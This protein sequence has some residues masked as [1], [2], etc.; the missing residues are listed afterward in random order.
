MKKIILILF[1]FILSACGNDD[2]S[3]PDQE[4]AIYSVSETLVMPGDEII[5]IGEGFIDPQVRF[6]EVEA[7]I[8][9]ST[10]FQIVAKV[11]DDASSGSITVFSGEKST[12]SIE[13]RVMYP[14]I[15]SLVDEG[16]SIAGGPTFDDLGYEFSS[17]VSGKITHLGVITSRLGNYEITL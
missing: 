11:P 10:E 3:K 7:D 16:F 17:T 8:V 2:E 14:F 1:I 5:I 9:T 4:L 15:K 12:E 13:I 6:N